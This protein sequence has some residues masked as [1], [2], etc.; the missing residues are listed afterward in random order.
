MLSAL[1]PPVCLMVTKPCAQPHTAMHECLTRHEN[2]SGARRHHAHAQN[3][4]FPSPPTAPT[5]YRPHRTPPTP[6]STRTAAC[7]PGARFADRNRP[8]PRPPTD[9]PQRARTMPHAQQPGASS[10]AN[11][12]AARNTDAPAVAWRILDLH[13]GFPVGPFVCVSAHGLR[14]CARPL[15]L[16]VGRNRRS[17][18]EPRLASQLHE[19][20][21]LAGWYKRF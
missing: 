1:T 19:A 16:H 9:P 13:E 11:K 14:A 12:L 15:H 21:L 20:G 8:Y 4:S 18:E 17:P 3:S 2:G 10:E 7:Q 6:I 5:L